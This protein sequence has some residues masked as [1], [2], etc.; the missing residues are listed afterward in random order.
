MKS[1]CF[2]L[3]LGL[4]SPA[5][6]AQTTSG[7]ITYRETI[8]LM[9]E[10]DGA[11]E[12]MRNM[13]PPSQSFEKQLI[14]TDQ[15]AIYQDGANPAGDLEIKHE[16]NGNDMQI[17]MKRP[18]STLYTDLVA[19]TTINAR[20]F[21]GRDFLITGTTKAHSWK[22]TGQQKKIGDYVCFQAILQD[23]SQQVVAWFSPQIPL[24]IGPSDWGKLPGMIL[25]VD[26]DNGQRTIV[27]TAVNLGP[28][29]ADAIIKP[30]KGKP[31]SQAEFAAI[32]EAKLKEMGDVMGGN[33]RGGVKIIIQEERH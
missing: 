13:I 22:M 32:E 10:I 33:G 5:L 26:I 11:D 8:K 29:A 19:G 4:L 14:F 12:A 16:E 2:L 25:E 15:Q 30:T 3:L 1:V 9:I 17:V 27:A 23:T 6:Q 18:A 31:V 7:Q 21:F 20:D 28:V 24:S